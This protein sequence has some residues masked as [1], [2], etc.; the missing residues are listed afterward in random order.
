MT[1]RDYLLT[2]ARMGGGTSWAAPCAAKSGVPGRS[3][4]RGLTA[5]LTEA[6]Q[7]DGLEE[8]TSIHLILI[9]GSEL[10]SSLQ[11]MCSLVGDITVKVRR[12]TIYCRQTGKSRIWKYRPPQSSAL[13]RQQALLNLA[14]ALQI[15][16]ITQWE[17][18]VR[19][20]SKVNLAAS[21]CCED[22]CHTY[23][24]FNL[25]IFNTLALCW[26]R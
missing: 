9:S 6:L 8:F 19:V 10:Q 12:Y 1:S 22:H 20:K 13:G 11:L 3:P 25:H 21:L 2:A 14:V 5:T 16:P 7:Q 4:S 23:C 26:I 15:G 17:L 18:E 24:V